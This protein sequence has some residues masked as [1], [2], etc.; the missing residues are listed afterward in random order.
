MTDTPANINGNSSKTNNRSYVSGFGVAYLDSMLGKGISIVRT[1]GYGL[2]VDAPTALIGE[3]GTYKSHLGRAFLSQCFADSVSEKQGVAVLLT[4]KEMTREKLIE[5]MVRHI[6]GNKP[7][8]IVDRVLCR[9]LEI[10]HLS[11][12]VLIHI[13]QRLIEAA[14][15]VL[16]AAEL[17]ESKCQWYDNQQDRQMRGWRI[18]FVIDNWT[19]IQDAYPEVRND[20][21]VLP[22]LVSYLQAEGIST[23]IIATKPGGPRKAQ[24]GGELSELRELTPHHLYTWHVPFY[25]VSRVAITVVPA[26]ARAIQPLVRELRTKRGDEAKEALE[27]NPHF[28]LY[29][30]LEEG[31]ASI[32][33]LRIRLYS[34]TEAVQPYVDDLNDLISRL[35]AGH[36]NRKDVTGEGPEQ[37]EKLREFSRL[38]RGARLSHTLVFQVDEFWAES[39]NKSSPPPLRNQSDY[40][41]QVT[42]DENGQAVDHEDPFRS[43]QLNREQSRLAGEK[44]PFTRR[45]FFHTIGNDYSQYE[46]NEHTIEKVPYLWDFGILLCREKAWSLASNVRIRGMKS[47]W[48]VGDI[49]DVLVKPEGRATGVDWFEF[50]QACV[51]VARLQQ[52]REAEVAYP[53]DL[54]MVATESLSCFAF[55]TWASEIRLKEQEKSVK[56]FHSYR[57]DEFGPSLTELLQEFDTE[58]YKAWLLMGEVFLRNQLPTKEVAFR[59]RAAHAFAIA[60]RHWYSTAGVAPGVRDGNDPKVV[61]GLP[62]SYTVRGD[63]F[64]AVARGSR[65]PRLGERAMDLLCTRRGDIIRLQ[66]GIGLPVRALWDT[67]SDRDPHGELWTPMLRF[68]PDG[69]LPVMYNEIRDLG[70]YDPSDEK[71]RRDFYWIWRS[72]IKGYD[73]HTRIWQRWLCNKLTQWGYYL[74]KGD[75]FSR[76]RRASD[77]K[78]SRETIEGSSDGKYFLGKCRQLRKTLE[79]A[80]I[81]TI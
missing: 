70:A 30:G 20:P 47:S 28:E 79:R 75:G 74:K 38:Q 31:R 12:A 77:E 10:H 18:R 29:E 32:V 23:L 33:P 27:V 49:W 65:S 26:I 14:Q 34:G 81:D 37:Y 67:K 59:G 43:F 4:T 25:G 41:K 35:V 15:K 57:H 51:E 42:V 52:E 36:G 69:P 80:T 63:W 45:E 78:W 9:R 68:T 44:R 39:R 40:L 7:P 22:F 50:L 11:P 2:P 24:E 5:R 8:I 54:S 71:G 58:L 64:L 55:E 56:L 76:Y 1:E 13:V 60:A 73:M 53:F 62:G 3:E 6:G 46:D 48:R 21:L 17:R 72:L 19:M 66:A 16:F 61:M